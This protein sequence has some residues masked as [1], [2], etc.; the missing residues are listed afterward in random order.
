MNRKMIAIG[1][2]TGDL[3]VYNKLSGQLLG[4]I[5][6]SGHTSHISKIFF[7]SFEKDQIDDILGNNKIES[8]YNDILGNNIIDI[9]MDN[10]DLDNP[11][12]CE[13]EE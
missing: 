5:D 2:Y 12:L 9:L 13:I 3:H 4:M 11:D 7:K 6:I 10:C 1:Y 8:I